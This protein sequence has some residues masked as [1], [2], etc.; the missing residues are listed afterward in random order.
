MPKKPIK[1]KLTEAEKK[2]LKKIKATVNR[3][4]SYLKTVKLRTDNKLLGGP[5]SAAR[6]RRASK[7]LA[8]GS[9]EDK[10]DAAYIARAEFGTLKRKLKRK[11]KKKE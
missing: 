2:K 1:K 5:T 3:T 10:R 8:S 9:F 6:Q 11:K 4:S 7:K